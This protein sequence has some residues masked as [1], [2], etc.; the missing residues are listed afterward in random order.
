M[1]HFKT[2][3]SIHRRSN[4][5]Y[6][7][8]VRCLFFD[9][10][11]PWFCWTRILLGLDCLTNC[12][13]PSPCLL[14]LPSVSW[15]LPTCLHRPGR[16]LPRP[17]PG[18]LHPGQQ[19][20]GVLRLPALPP[21]GPLRAGLPPGH[22]Q[23]RGLALHHHG[24]VLSSAPTRRH[25]VRHPRGRVHARVPLRLHTQRDESVRTCPSLHSPPPP[26]PWCVFKPNTLFAAL[27]FR[28]GSVNYQLIRFSRFLWLSW[29][30]C[31]N[32]TKIFAD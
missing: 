19:R 22:L 16:V 21:R 2:V 29:L 10:P 23:V 9:P 1:G 6:T 32:T 26:P 7:A 24:P 25:A 30:I 14:C 3:K 12:P 11:H 17:V 31:V 5:A 4:A 27:F 8:S 13:S 28:K 18:Q 20:H 15:A